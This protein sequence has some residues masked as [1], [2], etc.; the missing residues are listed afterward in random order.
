MRAGGSHVASAFCFLHSASKAYIVH[1]RQVRNARVTRVNCGAYPVVISSAAI[2]YLSRILQ[3]PS[4][5]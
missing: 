1:E 2:K 3:L 5:V 4:D